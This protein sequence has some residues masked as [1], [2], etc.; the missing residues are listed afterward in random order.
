MHTQKQPKLLCGHQK[1]SETIV[2]DKLGCQQARTWDHFFKYMLM[3]LQNSLFFPP[4]SPT[5][6]NM[7]A[8][9]CIYFW[10]VLSFCSERWF[11]IDAPILVAPEPSPAIDLD[12]IPLDFFSLCNTGIARLFTIT[13]E[14]TRLKLLGFPSRP[15]G[16]LLLLSNPIQAYTNL[17]SWSQQDVRWHWAPKCTRT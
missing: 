7:H 17:A 15:L 4:G 6:L 5:S 12:I 9:P 14:I 2:V 8:M 16:A 10:N 1:S 3:V 13:P 11:S